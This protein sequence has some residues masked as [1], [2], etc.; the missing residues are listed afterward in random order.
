MADRKRGHARGRLGGL[1]GDEDRALVSS[2]L[3]ALVPGKDRASIR[4]K[5]TRDERVAVALERLFMPHHTA[6]DGKGGKSSKGSKGSKGNKG[7]SRDNDAFVFGVGRAC[8][9]LFFC[10]LFTLDTPPV[11]ACVQRCC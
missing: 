2:L 9:S 1:G 3:P 10:S 8:V 6:G 11:C 7:T 5:Q 4:A